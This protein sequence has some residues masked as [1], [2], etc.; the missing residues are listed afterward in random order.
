M[1]IL[2]SGQTLYSSNIQKLPCMYMCDGMLVNDRPTF[3][4]AGT[5]TV[6]V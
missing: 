4:V 1:C 5:V 3:K 2:I 6:N